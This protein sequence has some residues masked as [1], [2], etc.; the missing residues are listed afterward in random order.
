MIRTALAVVVVLSAS[1][2]HLP[3][4]PPSAD[5][6]LLFADEFEG[7]S[8][9]T[10]FWNHR[11]GTRMD[12]LNRA[13]NVSVSGGALHIA[14]RIDSISG[15]PTPTGGGVISKKP[16]GYGY[17]ESRSKPYMAGT[18]VHSSF[19]QAGGG[20]NAN[21]RIFEIDSY[22]IDSGSS[23]GCNNLY[24]HVCP[25]DLREIPWPLRMHVPWKAAADGWFVDGYE[26]TPD[27]VI[28]YDDGHQV[29]RV[30]WPDLTAQ[31]VVWLTGLNGCGK[32]EADKLPGE[33]VFDYFRYYAKDHPGITL[34]PNGSFEYNQDKVDAHKPV[35]WTVTG[36]TTGVAVT[37]GDAA[38]DASFLRIG[39]ER[40][41]FEATVSQTLEH[42]RNGDYMLTAKARGSAGLTSARV[43]VTAVRGREETVSI[44][45]T[46]RWTTIEIPVVSVVDNAASIT[47]EA[48]G[49]AGKWLEIDD[50]RFMKPP[51]PGQRPRDPRPLLRDRTAPMWN[52]LQHPM[53]FPGDRSFCFF[54]RNVGLGDAITVSFAMNPS[55]R[56]DVSPIAR[57]PKKGT[58]G[59]MVLLTG[60]GDVVFR[61]GSE[62]SHTDVEA[63]A[64]YQ[65]GQESRVACVFDR[66]TATIY[67]DGR[68]LATKTGIP[69]TTNDTTE[70]GRLGTVNDAYLAVGEV[71][72]ANDNAGRRP[73][74]GEKLAKYTGSLRD[75]RV[76]N[77]ALD[78]TEIEALG[79]PAQR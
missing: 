70:P 69:Q 76:Y 23:L 58:D 40:E 45:A 57:L 53:N 60:E 3:A 35:A 74:R 68:R 75:V 44:A 30:E 71:I 18:G 54:D 12:G 47:I 67:V 66:G 22:E 34:L 52:A 17:Y 46:P 1:V 28:F 10:T 16:F 24:V 63:K 9:D 59:W 72:V 78:A 33:T 26:Y 65:P 61:I 50:V 55:R 13:E 4:A 29:A 43:R 79:K 36:S 31:Q 2:R 48:E 39:S 6:D 77:R 7:D 42:I 38:H 27:G 56:G 25:K 37:R 15:K 64:D 21:N 32:V 11:T 19:W 62:Q 14:V 8:L 73:E 5:Y 20:S 41:P 51:L 49:P